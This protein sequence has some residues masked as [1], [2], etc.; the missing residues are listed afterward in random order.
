MVAKR[1][2]DSRHGSVSD[3][4]TVGCVSSLSYLTLHELSVDSSASD[5]INAGK[6]TVTL[7][8]GASV[9]GESSFS[10]MKRIADDGVWQTRQN[11]LI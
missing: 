3:A 8:P 6:E 1:E 9:F 2:R 7:L 10:I 4:R 5:I 11:R